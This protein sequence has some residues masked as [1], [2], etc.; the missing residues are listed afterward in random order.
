MFAVS[1]SIS[2]QDVACRSP[3]PHSPA[4]LSLCLAK[5]SHGIT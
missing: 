3:A 4:S 2:P 5:G 1:G